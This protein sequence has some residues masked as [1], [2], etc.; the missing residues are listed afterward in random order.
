M[1]ADDS[2][3]PPKSSDAA[4]RFDVAESAAGSGSGDAQTCTRCAGSITASYYEVN[5]LVICPRC[6]GGL[7]AG[8]EGSRGRRVLTAAGLGLLAAIGGSVVY[9][10]IAALT[11][12]E[13]GLVA[14][15]VG[16]CV[17]KAVNKGSRGRG[18]WAYQTLAIVLTYF[19]IVSTYIP[20]AVREFRSNPAQ[21]DSLR[22]AMAQ[23]DSGAVADSLD[24]A[25]EDS[26]AADARSD[27][28]FTVAQAGTPRTK[29][30]TTGA[31]KAIHL[32]PGQ[33]ILGVIA[34]LALAAILPILAGFSNILGLIIIG[35]AVYQA[36]VLNKRVDL[37]ITGPY[38]VGRGGERAP[39]SG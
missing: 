2:S 27:S 35:F 31:A 22:T 3:Q 15:A 23:P 8:T 28:G 29:R 30:S 17:G 21:L 13:F 25:D 36:W 4:L 37:Q 10:V 12:Y 1:T 33:I 20:L 18:G 26:T 38:R 16:F 9:F 24:D 7:D 11:G 14:I 39:A 5:G 34:L 32:G 19:A 6:R